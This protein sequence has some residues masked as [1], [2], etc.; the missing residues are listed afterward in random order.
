MMGCELVA[1]PTDGAEEARFGENAL[2]R[3][4]GVRIM[5]RIGRS[6]SA[7]QKEV[8]V[9]QW[10]SA[11]DFPAVRL[12]PDVRQPLEVDGFPVT[13]WELL[14]AGVDLPT[15]SDLGAML[16]RLHDLPAPT[17]FSLP[18]FELLAK[19]SRRLDALPP[20]SFPE[21]TIAFLRRRRE[22]IE[23]EF[24]ALTFALPLGPIHGDAYCGNLLRGQD[25]VVRLIDFEDFAIGPREW[26]IAVEAMRFRSF[27]WISEQRYAEFVTAYGFDPLTWP[28]C[29]AVCAAREINMTTWLMQHRGRSEPMD[30]KIDRHVHDLLNDA[31]RRA[32]HA[33]AV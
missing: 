24:A 30:F 8:D 27:G 31:T 25:G 6:V 10:L 18:T 13:F 16:R 22:E 21:E 9:A 1:L 20:D 12:A 4:P 32:W 19:V 15:S 7:A 3:M 28:G 29:L 17:T 14:P 33:G 2:F 23:A 5:V 26:D 11:H